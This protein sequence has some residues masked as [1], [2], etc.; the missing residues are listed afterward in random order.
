MA[1]GED[2]QPL[3]IFLYT[4]GKTLIGEVKQRQPAGGGALFGQGAP[5]I[6]CGVN[7]GRVVAAAVQQHQI[8]GLRFAERGL[9]GGKVE[10]LGRR[11][12]VLVP[13][14]G[15]A[16]GLEH[17]DVVGP[18]GIGDPD[19]LGQTVAHHELG[20]DAQGT[21]TTRR[22]GCLGAAAGNQGG[23]LPEQQLLHYAAIFDI[24]FNTEVVLGLLVGEQLLLCFLD[25]MKD[26]SGT[27]LILVDP[28]PQIDLV[29]ARVGTE[30][31]GQAQDRIRWG[32]NNLFKHGIPCIPLSSLA[33]K[34]DWQTK[35]P[36]WRALR[37][38]FIPLPSIGENRFLKGDDGPPQPMACQPDARAHTSADRPRFDST[39]SLHRAR[40][41]RGIRLG[42]QGRASCR[43]AA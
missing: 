42:S 12:V 28:D 21:C 11:I 16:G 38:L 40:N 13:L 22:L 8:A 27:G 9:H 3:G 19:G 1:L 24:A 4:T 2:A 41:G 26:R 23:I 7:A 30:G 5:L 37:Q 15:E 18:G 34:V 36:L 25:A 6:S 10:T 14:D 29:A 32:G 17:A 43:G 20:G 39:R 31:F 33:G 35:A